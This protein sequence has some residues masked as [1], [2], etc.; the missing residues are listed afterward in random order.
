MTTAEALVYAA[1][2]V[3]SP[4]ARDVW[5]QTEADY[6]VS[7]GKALKSFYKF[8]FDMICSKSN[9]RYKFKFWHLY[10]LYVCLCSYS[11]S[12]WTFFVQKSIVT[13]EDDVGWYLETILTKSIVSPNPHLRQVTIS[14]TDR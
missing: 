5:T 1:M 11:Y 6:Q 3:T 8:L 10:L 4:A 2:G 7:K 13:G 12:N 14:P 9:K